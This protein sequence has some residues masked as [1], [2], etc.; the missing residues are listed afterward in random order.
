MVL[1]ELVSLSSLYYFLST[2]VTASANICQLMGFF[3]SLHL[4]LATEK[5]YCVTLAHGSISPAW[6]S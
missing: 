5:F 2:T 3:D 6:S 4:L 1:Q